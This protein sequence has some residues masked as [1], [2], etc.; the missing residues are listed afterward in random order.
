MSQPLLQGYEPALAPRLWASLGSKAMSQPLLQGYEPALAP[1]IPRT[2][3]G[4]IYNNLDFVAKM[5][6]DIGPC[7]SSVLKNDPFK[8]TEMCELPKTKL[9]FSRQ[10]ELLCYHCLIFFFRFWKYGISLRCCWDLV[11]EFSGTW[12]FLTNR[13]WAKI[14]DRL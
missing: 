3:V 10:M 9:I 4:Y 6:T 1:I 8:L 12:L 11:G 13:D 7:T 5:C 14:F 2:G